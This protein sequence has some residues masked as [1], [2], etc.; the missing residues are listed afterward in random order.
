MWELLIKLATMAHIAATGSVETIP[1]VGSESESVRVSNRDEIALIVRKGEHKIDSELS[2]H[3]FLTAPIPK[4]WCVGE[5]IYTVD[6]EMIKAPL[7][8][9][10]EITPYKKKSIFEKIKDK[11]F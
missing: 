1:V 3:R 6:G 7:L 5:M 2:L 4:D 10:T 8:N 9:E 11:I